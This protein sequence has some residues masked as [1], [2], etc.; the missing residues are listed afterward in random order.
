MLTGVKLTKR[1]SQICSKEKR[2][3]SGWNF[4]DL[5][6]IHEVVS[7]RMTLTDHLIN[8]DWQRLD[9]NRFHAVDNVLRIHHRAKG[10]GGNFMM[11]RESCSKTIESDEFTMGL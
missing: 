11:P 4:Q 8:V 6:T 2:D 7:V 3:I 5:D 10:N 1:V 9:H